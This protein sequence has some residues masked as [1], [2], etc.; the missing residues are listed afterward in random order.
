[1]SIIDPQPLSHSSLIPR[2]RWALKYLR[3]C[4][5]F[6]GSSGARRRPV[7]CF[8][9][10]KEKCNVAA[11]CLGLLARR[12]QNSLFRPEFTK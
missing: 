4:G 9:I 3:I 12:G 5:G 8:R 2:Q 6:L 11:P 1:M 10:M 7:A